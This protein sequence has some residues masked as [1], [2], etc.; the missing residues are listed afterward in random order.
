[1]KK[2]TICLAL[3]AGSFSLSAQT[4]GKIFQKE[5]KG[6]GFQLGS[7]KSANIILESV[8][9][10][11]SNSSEAEA[12]FYSDEMQKSGGDYNRKWHKMMKS[13]NN[14]PLSILPIK[15]QGSTDEIVM[16][17]STEERVFNNGSKQKVNLF[18]L[19]KLNKEGKIIDFNQ[20]VNI[21]ADNEFGKTSGGKYIANKPNVEVDGRPFQFSNRGEVASMEKFVKAYNAM[22]AKTAAEVMADEV[23]IEDFDG[24]KS[25]LKKDMLPAMFAEFKSLDWKP[26]MILPFK[27]K[28]TDPVSGAM[29]YATE[30]RVLKDGTVWEKNLVEF[31]R[32]NL[33][34]KIDSVEQFSRGLKK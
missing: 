19:F 5:D 24:N 17:Q 31:F 21:P 3:I 32:F 1:M 18:E 4:A 2:M 8:K 6:K 7:E 13:L 26:Y 25:I 27:L 16:L 33:D 29:V 9:A 30:K 12:V 34:G 22:D 15:V 23:I 10:Y 28:D 14:V 11:N 20:Y